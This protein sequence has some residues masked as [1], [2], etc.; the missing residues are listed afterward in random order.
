ME[1]IVRGDTISK[2]KIQLN[3][4]VKLKNAVPPKD[5]INEPAPVPQPSS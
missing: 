2:E 1:K 4:V 5:I 3:T